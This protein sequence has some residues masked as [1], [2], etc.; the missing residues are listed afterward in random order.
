MPGKWSLMDRGEKIKTAGKK[1]FQNLTQG[2][3]KQAAAFA[4]I[5]PALAD[6]FFFKKLTIQNGFKTRRARKVT[7]V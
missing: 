3:R 5:L 2:S 1:L 7:L 4:E 6:I